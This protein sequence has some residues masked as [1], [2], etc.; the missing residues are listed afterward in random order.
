[1]VASLCCSFCSHLNK[2]PVK[3]SQAKKKENMDQLT[4]RRISSLLN[5]GGYVGSVITDLTLSLISKHK[6]FSDSV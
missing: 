5:I 3:C 1:M 6:H 2:Y 4:C